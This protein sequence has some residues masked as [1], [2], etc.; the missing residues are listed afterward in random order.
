MK[1]ELDDYL[2]TFYE[3]KECVKNNDESFKK[4][5]MSV[6]KTVKELEKIMTIQ[7]YDFSYFINKTNEL[8]NTKDIDVVELADQMNSEYVKVCTSYDSVISMQKVMEAELKYLLLK[9]EEYDGQ[10]SFNI[11]ELR[12][13]CDWLYENSERQSSKLSIDIVKAFIDAYVAN[14]NEYKA[15]VADQNDKKVKLDNIVSSI[16]EK[17]AQLA[18]NQKKSMAD[19]MAIAVKFS[20]IFGVVSIIVAIALALFITRRLVKNLTENMNKLYQSAQFVSNA[21]T[22]LAGASQQLSEG[23]TEQAASIEETSATMEE[24]V[25]MI[26]RTAE[27][28][29]Q[30]NSISKEASDAASA[31]SIK[32]HDMIAAIEELKKSS[33][34]ISKIIKVIDQ[35]ALQTN[36]LA[37]NAAV[38]AARAG[39][40]GLGFAVVATE[41][42]DLAQKSAEAAKNTANIINKNI[43]LSEE[44]VMI[45][46]SVSK[47][48]KDIIEK[49]KDVNQIIEEI[50]VAS[51]EQARGAM[52]V[53]EAV[54][55]MEKIVQSNAATAEEL[56]LIHI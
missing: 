42:R 46:D 34:E 38:E 28:T 35:I 8:T 5:S 29:H 10:V 17:A 32:M 4:M 20:M 44:G 19:E 2:A 53:T 11:N 15:V 33:N 52:Q 7:K 27:N 49:T 54:A 56:S 37:L 1:T 31:G 45:S 36:M 22:Q 43:E 40:E 21:S 51:E 24:T 47:A 9:E 14:Y 23:S 41:V 16:S 13:Q 48:L 18:E 55:Q 3:Y 12:K 25:S 26:K 6:D 50:S 39:E 30:A